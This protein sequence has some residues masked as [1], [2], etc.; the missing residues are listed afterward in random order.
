MS[1]L[2]DGCAFIPVSPFDNFIHSF[3]HGAPGL[4]RHF[5]NLANQK[6]FRA[7]E[8]SAVT[9]LQFTVFPEPTHRADNLRQ[10]ERRSRSKQYQVLLG[11]L[12]PSR[13]RCRCTIEP[14]QELG[15]FRFFKQLTNASGMGSIQGNEQVAAASFQEHQ[16]IE[17]RRL[18][19]DDPLDDWTDETRAL[20][21]IADLFSDA[22]PHANLPAASASRSRPYFW[23]PPVEAAFEII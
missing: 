13:S 15:D 7:L 20:A 19:V 10:I 9:R 2:F 23:P 6:L 18:A 5:G 12:I 3:R 22:Q 4:P 1:C 8:R 17:F 16:M 14:V 11:T 21:R